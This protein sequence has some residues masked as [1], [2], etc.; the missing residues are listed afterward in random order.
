MPISRAQVLGWILISSLLWGAGAEALPRKTLN[1]SNLPSDI[2]TE[3]VKRFPQMEKDKVA[4]DQLDDVIRFLQLKPQF[5]NIRILDDGDNT[6][7][8]WNFNELVESP[9]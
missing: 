5:S 7:I 8:V 9:Q 2:Q 4:L 1:Y 6:L 3:L